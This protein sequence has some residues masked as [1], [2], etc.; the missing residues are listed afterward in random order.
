MANEYLDNIQKELEELGVKPQGNQKKKDNLTTR[1]TDIMDD[2]CLKTILEMEQIT[3]TKYSDE[4]KAILSTS[5]NTCILASAGSGKTTVSTHLIA[6]RIK[7]GEIKNVSKMIY[8]TYSKAGQLEMQGRLNKLLK[9]LNINENV[10]VRTL[11]SFF[12]QVLRTFGVN[13]EIIKEKIRSKYIREACDDAG[14]THKDDELM[15]VDN[16]LSFQVNNILS[17]KKTVESYVNTLDNLTLEQYSKIRSGYASRK[18]AKGLIDYD[19]MQSYLYLWLVKFAKSDKESERQVAESVR[20]YCKA[21][22]TDFYIDEAQDVSKIQFAILRAIITD[23]NDKNKLT[24]GLVFIGDDDQCIYTWRG[25]DPSIIL[26]IGPTFN[27]QTNQLTTNYR[28]LSE[29]VDYASR[30]IRC[31]GNRYEK[32]MKASNHGGSV[33]IAVSDRK[34][35]CS[36]SIV[37]LNQIK[38]WLKNGENLKDIAVL[39]RNNFHLALLSNMLLREGIY[40]NMTED[41]KLTKS[42]MYQDIK[43]LIDITEPN[44]NYN[45][46]EKILWKLCRYMGVSN[47][48]A[49]ANFQSNCALT[50][51][52]ALGYIVKHFINRN[53][54]FDKR[55]NVNLQAE[56]K[57]KYFIENRLQEDTKND[58]YMV[59]QALSNPNKAEC[60]KVLMFQYVEQSSFLY[61]TQDKMRS[62]LGLRTYINNLLIKDGFDK[63]KDFLRV[64]EQLEYGNMVIP[65]EKMT[66]T[67]IH[68]AKGREWKNVI[69]FASDNVSEPSFDGIVHMIE[70][71]I[72]VH[73]ICEHLSEERR[74]F[75][76][77]NTRAKE[78]LVT[79]TSTEP[80]VFIL[81]NLGIIDNTNNEANTN[82]IKYAQNK[83]WFIG[84]PLE[85]EFK[86]EVFDKTSKYYYDYS[87]Y[88]SM[89]PQNK[90]E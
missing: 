37:A 58:I 15:L 82:I 53:I 11:H 63:M 90:T 83:D 23:P 86:K 61:K 74:L 78:N 33:K 44:W 1:N 62:I 25:S 64:T 43:M 18:V 48:K 17:D 79:I 34:D 81:E 26:T 68:S 56:E 75:Y 73:D 41:M 52:D 36:L 12:L 84:T 28:C 31:N 50:L 87:L 10:S 76:V 19:D 32:T 89:Q 13:S 45:L 9:Q 14:F 30:G 2:N 77:G 47:S 72:S 22:W 60:L 8:T 24:A 3:G 46:T 38:Y 5:G 35:L 54:A 69:M 66:L 7:T 39:S 4:Q 51:V 59:Y 40:C 49:I 27:M 70:D 57:I 55:L 67:T 88:T 29:I 16:L 80:S 42:Y 21:M 85:E 71:G 20:N 65:G 6:K